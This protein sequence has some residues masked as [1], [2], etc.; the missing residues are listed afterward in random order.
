ME[1]SLFEQASRLKLVFLTTKGPLTTYELWDLPLTRL[2]ELAK[3]ANRKIRAQEEED[4]IATP[5]KTNKEDR[6]RLE[7]LKRIIEVRLVEK[8]IRDQQE[9]RKAERDL[10]LQLKETK[11]LEKLQNLT[12]EEIEARLAQ[13]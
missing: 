13:L 11:K 8:E 5:T 12:E 10:L 7:V 2:N 6:L 4:F 3:E 1:L 9:Q